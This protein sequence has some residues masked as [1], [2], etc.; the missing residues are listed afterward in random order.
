M[1]SGRPFEG[2]PFLSF[3]ETEYRIPAEKLAPGEPHQLFIEHA[4]V[5]TSRQ[6]EV[7]GL[8]TYAA[9]TFLDFNTTGTA[10]GSPC[11]DVMPRMDGGQ[12]DRPAP[13]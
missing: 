11:P 13:K 2:T 4:I 8:V 5:D 6:N 3:T 12:T 9:T 7:V 1:H 10:S